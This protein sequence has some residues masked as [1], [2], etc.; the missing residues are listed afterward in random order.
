[1]DT[2]ST[3]ASSIIRLAFS[4]SPLLTVDDVIILIDASAGTL[5]GTPANTTV[6]ASG[7]TFDLY[8]NNEQLIAKVTAV[9]IRWTG[10]ADTADCREWIF[11][12]LAQCRLTKKAYGY[13]CPMNTNWK[14]AT[15]L[16]FG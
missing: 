7:Y 16:S 11:K 1:M 13:P 10:A 12:H 9:P 4:G 15:V 8:V 5:T 3:F 14:Q 2:Y 6:T